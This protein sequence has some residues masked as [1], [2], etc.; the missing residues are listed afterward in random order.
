MAGLTLD[1]TGDEL[2]AG[3][4]TIANPIPG[5]SG[6]GL[7]RYADRVHGMLGEFR[8]TGWRCDKIT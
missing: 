8:N 4:N 6:P 2:D 1:P 3:I 7:D 5:F